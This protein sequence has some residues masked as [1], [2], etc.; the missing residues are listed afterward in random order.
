[1]S[2]IVSFVLLSK[3]AKLLAGDIGRFLS[4]NWQDL[5]AVSGVEEGES[6]LLFDIGSTKI[7]LMF[8][9]QPFPWSDL[10][11]PCATSVLWKDAQ[12]SLQDHRAHIIISALGEL[13]AIGQATLLTQV[14][15]AV[16]GACDSALGVYWGNA[17]L[18]VPKPIF[19]DFAVEVL[20][21]GPPLHIWVDFR[22]GTG[23]NGGSVGFTTGMSGL[24]HREIEAIDAPEAPGALRDRLTALC[25]YLLENGPVIHDGNTVGAD[26]DEKIR[27]VFAESRFGAQ[28]EV[29]LLEY[30][31][32]T[33]KKPKWKFW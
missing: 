2:V 21:S 9:D 31:G 22:V 18:I 30:E 10:E 27:V 19:I 23:E 13:T 17:A 1:M 8:M 32:R 11:G 3:P 16:L 29:M 20:P 14:T 25:G 15:A 12:A 4:A 5:P 33:S 6:T 26:A 7:A 24:G 28:S